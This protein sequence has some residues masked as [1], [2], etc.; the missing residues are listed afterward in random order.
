MEEIYV[1]LIDGNIFEAPENYN[2]IMNY[3]LDID[4]LIADG[5][6][7]L[8]PAEIPE[9][10]NR[11]FHIEY[12]ENSNNIEEIVIYDETQEQADARE[13][14]DRK[15]NKTIEINEKISE[16]ET[17]S[18]Q[19]IVNGNTQN[20]EIYKDIINGLIETRDNL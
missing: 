9:H 4:R 11:M 2:G 10:T 19:E 14:A 1:K 12:R 20:I 8:I 6:K 15:R 13:A 7:I 5:W 3:N 16:L 18:V 17:K